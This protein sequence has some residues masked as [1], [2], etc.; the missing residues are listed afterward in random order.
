MAN[1]LFVNLAA[2]CF[3]NPKIATAEFLAAAV[4]Q[5]QQNQRVCMYLPRCCVGLLLHRG[6]QKDAI[7][8]TLYE[9]LM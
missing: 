5:R 3:R 2:F 4:L 6:F 9:F 1:Q 7:C 8:Y